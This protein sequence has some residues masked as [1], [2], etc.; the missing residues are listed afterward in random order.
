MHIEFQVGDKV[1]L[2]VKG[3]NSSLWLGSCKNLVARFCGPF[4]VLRKTGLVAYELALPPMF[5]IH[6]I[7]H[8]SLLKKYVYDSN[9][10]LYWF[11][12]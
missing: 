2:K 9:H 1:F 10:I 3:K 8:V 11:V 5:K 6:N 4:K 12:I 7:F